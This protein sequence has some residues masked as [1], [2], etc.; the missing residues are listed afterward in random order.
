MY[1]NTFNNYPITSNGKL[2]PIK[3]FKKISTEPE[4]Y[5]N[6]NNLYTP[7]YAQNSYSAYEEI[8][9]DSNSKES[10]Q[11]VFIPSEDPIPEDTVPQNIVESENNYVEQNNMINMNNNI[12]NFGN[13]VPYYAYNGMVGN[14]NYAYFGN[15]NFNRNIFNNLNY[16]TPYNF[17]NI[18]N[19][20]N[21]NN[22]INCH[23][24]SGRRTLRGFSFK[25][26]NIRNNLYNYNN[27]F[28]Y[29]NNTYNGSSFNNIN[30]PISE[31]QKKINLLIQRC[32]SNGIAPPD[33]DFSYEGWKLFYNENDKF[34]LWNKGNKVKNTIQ[35][36]NENDPE[37]LEIYEGEINDKNER[38]GSGILVTPKYVRKGTWRNNE[39]TGWC[40]ESRRNGDIYEGKFIDGQIFGKG[41]MKNKNILYVGDFVE[42]KKNGEGEL[43]TNKIYYKGDFEDDKFSKNGILD[44]L[45]EGHRYEGEFKDNEITGM[46]IFKW[47]GG[48]IYEGSFLKGNM[49]GYGKYISVTGQ[50]YEGNYVNG[51]KHGLGRLVYQNGNMYEGEFVDGEPK[52]EGTVTINGNSFMVEYVNG[53]FRRK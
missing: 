16:N 26:S 47:K 4:Q 39:F 12:N 9:S 11:D 2:I 28:Q 35:I 31:E 15:N 32:N 52:G 10:I 20:N 19:I 5:S 36:L 8:M 46:G 3:N 1:S 7:S 40:R 22:N 49:H 25:R 14:N 21:I 33:N 34:F 30:N 24:F 50:S 37:N 13:N 53:K 51:K 18:N 23:R 48:D 45:I 38:H 42:N 27:N 43:S 41:I 29:N 44:F 6:S 17:N